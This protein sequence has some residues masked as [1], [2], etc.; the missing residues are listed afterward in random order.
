MGALSLALWAAGRVSGVRAGD[1]QGKFPSALPDRVCQRHGRRGCAWPAL[2]ANVFGCRFVLL[3]VLLC[4]LCVVCCAVCCV[5]C[6]VL[7]VLCCVLCLVV[8]V[9]VCVC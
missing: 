7:C 4:V 9:C 1:Q 6:V 5:L 3:R 8:C 2:V